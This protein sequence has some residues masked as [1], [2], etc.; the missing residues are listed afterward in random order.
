MNMKNVIKLFFLIC[1]FVITIS[2]LEGGAMSQET[3]SLASVKNIPESQ[4][5]KLTGEK[6]FFG[7]QSVGYNIVEGMEKIEE[8]VPGIKLNIVEIKNASDMNGA[9]F[10]HASIGENGDPHSKMQAF[11]DYVESGIGAKADIAFFKFCYV[12]INA[13]SDIDKIFIEYKET[14]EK[15][16]KKYPHMIFIHST[17]PLTESKTT[18]RSIIKAVL[19]KEDHNIKRN[20]FNDMLRKEYSGR[21][22]LFDIAQAESTRPDGTKSTFTKNGSIYYSLVTEYTDDDGHLNDL[23]Q[24][25]VAQDLLILLAKLAR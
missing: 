4:W 1:L 5:Q 25:A 17:V 11:T 12:D 3:V 6:I 21:E 15:L 14:M 23:G 9:E 2:S 10:A 24:H 19:G 8:Q 7:H 13:Y 22:P 20:L 18:V 16:K